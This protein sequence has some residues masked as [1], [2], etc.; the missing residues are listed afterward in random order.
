M[1]KKL[2]AFLD[3]MTSVFNI[4]PQSTYHDS[5]YIRPAPFKNDSALNIDRNS[6][7]Q[8]MQ[9]V[10]TQDLGEALNQVKGQMNAE[11][12]EQFEKIPQLHQQA[13]KHYNKGYSK[14]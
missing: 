2:N 4:M 10:L 1:G 13:E 3:G 12:R 9:K 7:A 8:S 6:V 5:N 11:V 14:K